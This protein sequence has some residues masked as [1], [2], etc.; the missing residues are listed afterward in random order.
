MSA[1]DSECPQCQSQG[2]YRCST[3]LQMHSTTKKR[4]N[5]PQDVHVSALHCCRGLGPA[6]QGPKSE[7]QVPWTVTS[8]LISLAGR[9]HLAT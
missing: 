9:D 4:D 2:S 8:S 6:H 3:S 5:S 1:A 7:A